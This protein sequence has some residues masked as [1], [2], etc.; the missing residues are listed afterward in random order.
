MGGDSIFSYFPRNMI[1]IHEI[2]IIMNHTFFTKNTNHL[3]NSWVDASS[4]I[5][6][7]LYHYALWSKVT[8][9]SAE[10]DFQA[11]RGNPKE[12]FR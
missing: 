1:A 8:F 6:S 2:F 11:T 3:Q 7:Q 5:Y 4:Q 9:S 10:S 12:L